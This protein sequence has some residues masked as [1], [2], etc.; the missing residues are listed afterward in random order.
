[1]NE[2]K[3]NDY[4]RGGNRMPD[5][6]DIN[7]CE[8]G[9]SQNRY[10]ELKY[11]CLQYDE[12]KVQLRYSTDAL[13]SIPISSVPRAHSAIDIT[14]DLAMRRVELEKNCELIEQ[15][16]LETDSDIY[17][18][19]LEAVTNDSTFKYLQ[20]MKGIPCGHNYFYKAK[21]RFYYLL[22]KNKVG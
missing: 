22:D 14:A 13:K 21:K 3:D 10:R 9:I 2:L 11:F 20:M 4:I 1:M 7:L 8:Y 15:T 18:Y 17:T 16:A 12:W 6:R 19:I 5:Q